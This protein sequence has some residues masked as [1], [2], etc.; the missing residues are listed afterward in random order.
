MLWLLF[1]VSSA[2]FVTVKNMFTRKLVL[3]TGRLAV[4]YSGFL[5]VLVCSW[6]V[7]SI[8]GIPEI[9]PMF[10][11][12]IIG[13]S[14]IDVIAVGSL[15]M[16]FSF[17]E[18]S[19]VYP[20]TSFTPAFLLGT[21]F[22]ILGEVPSLLGLA[23][24]LVIALGSYVLKITEAR[25]GVLKPFRLLFTDKGPRFM[26][27]AALLFSFLGPLFKLAMANSSIFFALA[28]SQVL[29]SLYLTVYFIARRRLKTVFK[30]MTRH[31]ALVIGSGVLIYL[32]AIFLFMAMNLT[33]VAYAV[34]V[35]RISILL[36]VILGS[37]IFREKHLWRNI[38]A[39]TIMLVGVI[40]ISFS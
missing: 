19:A 40:L 24:V 3:V 9:K 12:A 35:K 25:A 17:G 32:Q 11:P 18:V 21:S 4:L 22:L 13:A 36:S 28:F 38:A 33:L 10:Y 27:V 16:A 29:S 34:S 39:G 23:G 15:I 8:I 6:S 5:V 1:A 37:L 7:V 26:I 2:L 14:L 31:L 30:T 20:I